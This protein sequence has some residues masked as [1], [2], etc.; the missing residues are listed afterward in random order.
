MADSN[1]LADKIEDPKVYQKPADK[2]TAVAPGS[3]AL[4]YLAIILPH[5]D[6]HTIIGPATAFKHLLPKII[7]VISNSPRAIEKFESISEIEDLW[8]ESEPNEEFYKNG[9]ETFVVEGQHDVYT[10]LKIYREEDKEDVCEVLPAPIYTVVAAGPL[11]QPTT[12]KS[13]SFIPI[14]TGKPFG[15]AETKRLV[16]TFVESEPAMHAAE[17][18]MQEMVKDLKVNRTVAWEQGGKKGGIL[19]AMS[20]GM[21][22]EVRVLYEDQVLRRVKEGAD[23]EGTKVGWRF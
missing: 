12:T 7:N 20:A 18:A 3:G 5:T 15:Y 21:L 13:G 8:G 1:L 17:E 4:F 9:F 2:L 23:R 11:V 6:A 14:A 16:A 22:W 19:M 10:V